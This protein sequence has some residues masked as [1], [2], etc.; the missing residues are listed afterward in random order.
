MK[1]EEAMKA[2]AAGPLEVN[3]PSWYEFDERA[4]MC[5]DRVVA[6]CIRPNE[7]ALLAHWAHHGPKLLEALECYIA[8]IDDG[9]QR[10]A[11]GKARKAI[12]A[13]SEVEG[14]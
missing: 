11:E 7:A 1:V 14:I 3:R 9:K 4:L 5:G 13:A 8:Q 2:A 10:M 12:A 6:H